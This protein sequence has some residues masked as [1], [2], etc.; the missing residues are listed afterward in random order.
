MRK[1]FMCLL[2]IFVSINTMTSVVSSK[3][4]QY[5]IAMC[6]DEAFC[7]KMEILFNNAPRK[8][9]GEIIYPE[10][11]YFSAIHWIKRDPPKSYGRMDYAP[12]DIN[13][14]GKNEI[15]FRIY[16]SLSCL[17][18]TSLDIWPENKL[19]LNAFYSVDIA[20]SAP[21]KIHSGYWDYPLS[22]LNIKP[23]LGTLDYQAS[24]NFFQLS[25]ICII[26]PFIYNGQVYVALHN[27]YLIKY[28]KW[29]VIAKYKRG[30]LAGRS[31]DDAADV[32]EDICYLEI[33]KF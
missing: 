16:G 33:I 24:H 29:L 32:L 2:Y 22:E 28:K 1:I 19:D 8:K 30:R 27:S 6:K 15:V 25:G 13:N 21:G 5:K 9:G 12:I 31:G 3:E 26:T 10:M 20:R 17:E 14:D 4:Y 23:K 7:K 11:D 18:I